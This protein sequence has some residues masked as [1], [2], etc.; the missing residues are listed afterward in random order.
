[1]GWVAHE[2][3]LTYDHGEDETVIGYERLRRRPN[4]HYDN[5]S[6]L[7]FQVEARSSMTE[8]RRMQCVRTQTLTALQHHSHWRTLGSSHHPLHPENVGAIDG[9]FITLRYRNHT[10]LYCKSRWRAAD[11]EHSSFSWWYVPIG[12]WAFGSPRLQTVAGNIR[13]TTGRSVLYLA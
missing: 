7:R 1:M 8:A 12:P 10:G 3:F 4:G 6:L 13:Q 5:T 11:G 2:A 9:L